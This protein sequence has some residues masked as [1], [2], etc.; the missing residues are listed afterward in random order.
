MKKNQEQINKL[1]PIIPLLFLPMHYLVLKRQFKHFMLFSDFL[2]N[3]IKVFHLL[4]FSLTL[5]MICKNN[6]N[7]L[8]VN[9][10]K[11]FH[12]CCKMCKKVFVIVR[13]IGAGGF[14]TT[15]LC[16]TNKQNYA[17]KKI[18]IEDIESAKYALKEYQILKELNHP[19]ITK[20]YKVNSQ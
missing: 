1:I 9:K 3:S 8:K 16:R 19:N 5:Y 14:G 20:V 12:C 7:R 2:E 13:K 11:N 10:S 18:S 17:L 4:F 6:K 15:Y